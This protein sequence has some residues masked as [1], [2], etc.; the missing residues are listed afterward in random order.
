M[1]VDSGLQPASL[2]SPAI[3]AH[4]PA[5]APTQEFTAGSS[6]EGVPE[7]PLASVF[8]DLAHVFFRTLR[9]FLL[10]YFLLGVVAFVKSNLASCQ[11]TDR[12]VVWTGDSDNS[13]DSVTKQSLK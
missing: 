6:E 12:A 5:R 10:K 9:I 4:P 1:R 7:G 3:P 8:C 2:D 13:R 11:A